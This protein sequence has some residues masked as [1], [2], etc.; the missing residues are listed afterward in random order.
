MTLLW[1]R[2]APWQLHGHPTKVPRI[3]QP[4][5]W[6]SQ[7]WSQTEQGP[8]MAPFIGAHNRGPAFVLHTQTAHC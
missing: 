6:K 1:K 8:C 5:L 3:L 7:L 2:A 4:L